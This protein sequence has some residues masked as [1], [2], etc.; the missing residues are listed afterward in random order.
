MQF[1]LAGL[2]LGEVEQIVDDIEKITPARQ[3]VLGVSGEAISI[4]L[5]ILPRVAKQFGESDD[6]YER[7]AQLVRHVGEKLTLDSV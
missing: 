2:D 4:R 6:R 7:R 5:R 3:N 1:E